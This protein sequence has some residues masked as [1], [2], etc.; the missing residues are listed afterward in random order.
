MSLQIPHINLFPIY[1]WGNW[2]LSQWAI[3]CQGLLK[4]NKGWNYE[5]NSSLCVAKL[6][7]TIHCSVLTAG[8]KCKILSPEWVNSSPRCDHTACFTFHYL[9]EFGNVSHLDVCA[10]CQLDLLEICSMKQLPV[11]ACRW[12]QY[13]Y[14]SI[15]RNIYVFYSVFRIFN[16]PNSR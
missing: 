6:W 7:A 12:S 9:K 8:I 13:W 15:Q 2:D 5:S 4:H 1:R 14:Y 10:L 3:G 11:L 16:I